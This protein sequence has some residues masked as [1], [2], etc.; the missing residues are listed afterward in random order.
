MP[1]T[2]GVLLWAQSGLEDD[3]SAYED[4]VLALL[5]DH[6]GRVVSRLRLAEADGPAEL[7]VIEFESQEGFESYLSDP[8]RTVRSEERD[9]VILRTD[10]FRG[11]PR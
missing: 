3:L 8:R 7:Q 4:E 1:I 9:R 2:L 10:L 11:T 6:N 5:G